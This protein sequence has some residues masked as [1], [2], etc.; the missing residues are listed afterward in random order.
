MSDVL[1]DSSV[2]IDF[3]RGVPEARKRLD[4]LLVAGRAA[5]CGPVYAEILS[6]ARERGT[7]DR[8]A[9]VLLSQRR[10]E[11]PP[12]AWEEVAETRFSLARQGLQANIIDLLIALT[13]LHSGHS[14]LARDRDFQIIGRAL[15]VEIEIF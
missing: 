1:V 11:A 15:P 7:F 6:G 3:F 12:S 10:L 4:P 5:I 14:L 9:R 13:A 2:W 8:L